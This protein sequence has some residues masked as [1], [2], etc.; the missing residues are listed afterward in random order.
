MNEVINFYNKKRNIKFLLA[1]TEIPL[2]LEE[3]IEAYPELFIDTTDVLI[4]NAIAWYQNAPI[5]K[6][7]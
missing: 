1:C 6:V 3:S 7:A 4:K 5:A 2:I